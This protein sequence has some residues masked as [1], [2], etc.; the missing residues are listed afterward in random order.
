VNLLEMFAQLVLPFK[1]FA[2][3]AAGE[4]AALRVTHHVQLELHLASK[5]L[6]AL[7]AAESATGH[8]VREKNENI[9]CTVVK[10]TT[11]ISYAFKGV[12]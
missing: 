8:L 9:S 12:G 2:A 5:T 3:L 6:V 7:C 1:L 11:D 10:S 4:V